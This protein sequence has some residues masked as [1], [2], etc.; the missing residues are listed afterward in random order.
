MHF[1]RV[2][3]IGEVATGEPI[4]APEEMGVNENSP[5]NADATIA[6]WATV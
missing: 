6:V 5:V 3:M 1:Q 2:L 4:Y